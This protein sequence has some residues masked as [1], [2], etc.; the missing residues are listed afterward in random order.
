MFVI[1]R[2]RSRLCVSRVSQPTCQN[3]DV[4]ALGGK[5]TGG[6]Y[7]SSMQMLA[8]E[9]NVWTTSSVALTPRIDFAA[10]E[11]LVRL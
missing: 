2:C 11:L 5:A 3:G 8:A 10:V 7:L 9:S 6:N 1:K 4:L